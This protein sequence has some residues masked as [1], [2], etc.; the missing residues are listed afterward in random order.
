MKCSAP[1]QEAGAEWSFAMKNEALIAGGLIVAAIVAASLSLDGTTVP[2]K[3]MAGGSEACIY[4][5]GPMD[6][7]LIDR[8]SDAGHR[9]LRSI[10]ALERKCEYVT[11]AL[12]DGTRQIM[13]L[14]K[15]GRA[16]G[17]PG[18]SSM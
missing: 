8:G 7:E 17:D 14:G 18:P 13:K 5:A 1:A 10:L 11:L 3:K 6:A 9:I 2:N 12:P 15:A 16:P 4:H